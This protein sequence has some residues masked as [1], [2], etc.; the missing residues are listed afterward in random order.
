MTCDCPSYSGRTITDPQR[1]AGWHALVEQQTGIPAG[2][3][4]TARSLQAAQGWKTEA[5][6][7]HKTREKHLRSGKSAPGWRRRAHHGSES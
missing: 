6:D 2:S 3:V 1:H 7:D 5:P 4:V